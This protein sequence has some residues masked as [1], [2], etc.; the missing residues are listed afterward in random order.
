[1]KNGGD[2][3]ICATNDSSVDRVA[4]ITHTQCLRRQIGRLFSHW[5]SKIGWKIENSRKAH[6]KNWR[7]CYRSGQLSLTKMNKKYLNKKY[8]R[9]KIWHRQSKR[10]NQR[11]QHLKNIVSELLSFNKHGKNWRQGQEKNFSMAGTVEVVPAKQE[12]HREKENS[13]E[14]L[15]KRKKCWK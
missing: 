7:Q 12:Y 14:A 9:Y 1:M 2:S 11:K 13:S 15:D 6:R 10:C 5:L 8:R 3:R 4:P